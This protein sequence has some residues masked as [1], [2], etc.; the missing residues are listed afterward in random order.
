[1]P[2]VEPTRLGSAGEQYVGYLV[3]KGDRERL[4]IPTQSPAEARVLLQLFP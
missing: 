2:Q 1:M 4:D 3:I